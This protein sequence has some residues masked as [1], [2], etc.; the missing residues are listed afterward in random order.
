MGEGGVGRQSCGSEL[1][2]CS[3]AQ[4][5][6]QKPEDGVPCSALK[7]QLLLL[8]D[9]GRTEGRYLSWFATAEAMLAGSEPR[10]PAPVNETWK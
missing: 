9:F 7:S 3:A 10:G 8:D 1:E 6:S 5:T 2:K 4:M